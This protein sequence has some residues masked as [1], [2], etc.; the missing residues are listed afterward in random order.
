M[1]QLKIEF[2]RSPVYIANKKAYF[3]GWPV[4]CNEEEV[5]QVRRTALFNY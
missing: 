4:I 2:K 1:N 5:G 3:D